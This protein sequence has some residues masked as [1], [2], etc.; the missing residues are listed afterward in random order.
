MSDMVNGNLPGTSGTAPLPYIL[1]LKVINQ[2]GSRSSPRNFRTA[3]VRDVL[4]TRGSYIGL[5]AVPDL[6]QKCHL[7]FIGD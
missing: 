4:N 6:R 1:L 3:A 7:A 2:I 5:E